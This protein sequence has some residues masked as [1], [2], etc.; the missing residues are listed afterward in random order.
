MSK[1]AAY[2]VIDAV[3]AGER[4]V[5]LELDG[6]VVARRL[7]GGELW[8]TPLEAA[9]P[10]A[11][12]LLRL[13]GAE[14]VLLRQ[15]DRLTTLELRDGAVAARHRA[16]LDDR[17][18]LWS[19]DGACG[20]RGKCSMQLID[21]AS[22]RPLGPAKIGEERT[23]IDPDGGMTSGCW[24]FDLD[25]VG[26]ARDVVVFFAHNGDGPLRGAGALGVRARDGGAVWRSSVIACAYCSSEQYGMDGE[27]LHCF[28]GS[29]D[30]LT[31]FDCLRGTIWFSKQVPGIKRALWAG[32]RGGGVFVEVEGAALL[33]DPKTGRQRWRVPIPKGTLALPARAR[34]TDL[35]EIGLR[36]ADKTTLA[37]LDEASGAVVSKLSYGP[38]E[39]VRVGDDGRVVLGAP[40]ERDHTGQVV[41]TPGPRPVTVER[42]RAPADGAGPPN[43]ATLRSVDGAALDEL[44]HDAWELGWARADAEVFVAV[45]IASEPREV[46]LYR[47]RDRSAATGEAAPGEASPEA[48]AQAEPEPAGAE[49]R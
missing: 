49:G 24:S 30:Q 8:R 45:M 46:W 28:A 27:G 15:Q 1:L 5:T 14:R 10:G 12:L 34:L 19:R 13:P 41:P 16:L 32:E 2:P 26:R 11:Q 4:L 42:S 20:L 37:L 23:M 22:G 48:P 7:D 25:L 47:L 18:Y 38:G 33:F 35:A 3:V 29:D 36:V 44:P 40:S 43:Q 17:L 9:S 31:V 21:C 39:V 6:A